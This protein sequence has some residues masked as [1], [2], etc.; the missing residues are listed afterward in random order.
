MG[1]GSYISKVHTGLVKALGKYRM[2]QAPPASGTKY[3]VLEVRCV[4]V[5]IHVYSTLL[6]INLMISVDGKGS[7]QKC[8]L[9]I[10]PT[11]AN[12]NR[13]QVS[14]CDGDSEMM[15]WCVVDAG[16]L[17]WPILPVVKFSS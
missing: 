1:F 17:K 13:Y 12:R 2:F 8:N 11:W 7:S 3:L 14:I 5:L 15:R 16:G 9:V 10:S 4:R 6:T